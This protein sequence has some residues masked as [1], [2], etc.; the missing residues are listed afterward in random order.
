MPTSARSLP[1]GR[2]RTS[3]GPIQ[4]PAR[5]PTASGS[6]ADHHTGPKIANPVRHGGP[7][8]NRAPQDYQRPESYQ[9]RRDV[10]EAARRRQ[11]QQRSAGPAAR[12]RQQAEPQHPSRLPG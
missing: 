12:R 10:H 3:A 1:A 7:Q 4:P 2:R 11:Q 8:R 5:K 6:A 9:H